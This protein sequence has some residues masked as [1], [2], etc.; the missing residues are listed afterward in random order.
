MKIKAILNFL[1]T[2][3][4]LLM[5]L[6]A[7]QSD[8]YIEK[9]EFNQVYSYKEDDD[10]QKEASF[11]KFIDDSH[12]VARLSGYT[13]EKSFGDGESYEIVFLEGR[14]KKS[15]HMIILGEDFKE[16]RLTFSSQENLE[17]KI[18]KSYYE[19]TKSDK[20]D[21]GFYSFERGKISKIDEV[22]QFELQ[23]VTGDTP[24][25]YA[26]EW[27][28]LKLTDQKLPSSIKELLSQYHVENET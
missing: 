11:I 10:S 9:I 1:V 8:E 26:Y 7:C 2:C 24:P 17:K 20:E 4:V 25:K 3:A 15:N 18:F 13:P 27:I 12:Y 28:K 5:I 23:I 6:A 16:V 14:Y 19:R 22:L 21:S